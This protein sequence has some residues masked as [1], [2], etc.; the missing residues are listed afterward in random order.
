MKEHRI[1]SGLH[2]EMGQRAWELL[3]E[4]FRRFWAAEAANIPEYCEFPDL[5]LGAQWE[6]PEKEAFYARYC[7]ME[8][9]KA[10]PH[11]P[12]DREWRGTTFG[13]VPDP[14][15]IY[16]ALGCYLKRT[17]DCIAAGDVTDSA[18]FAG[19]GAHV[20]QDCSNPG[21]VFNNIMLNRLFPVRGQKLIF[22]HRLMDS[23]PIDL[24]AVRSRP[25]LLGRNADEAV[26]YLAE[27]II[28]N[29]GLISA[30]MVKLCQA[31]IANRS[32]TITSI[33]QKWNA[34]AIRHTLNFWHTAFVLAAGELPSGSDR[35][36]AETSLA[37]KP[38]ITAYDERFDRQQ[39]I[40]A[41][42]P[43]YNNR[44]PESDP[45]RSTM[46][47]NPYP[48]EPLINCA[49]SSEGNLLPLQ[50]DDGG[51]I[52]T[53]KGV[54]SGT[55]GVATW[56]VPGNVFR[57]FEAAA[58]LHPETSPDVS[59]TFGV[60][61]CESTPRLLAKATTDRKKGAIRFKVAIPPE[62]RTL[63]LLN[64]GGDGR[65]T[66]VWLDPVLKS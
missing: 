19:T 63:S 12:Q 2:K 27:K 7:I 37:D 42:I 61:C 10:A 15:K 50:L 52:L 66:A 35:R 20:I 5:H 21:H 8:N 59:C 46:S 16:N 28:G 55:Y 49:C 23:W 54:A 11:G 18:R 51:T 13:D 48:F 65:S 9:G 40:A 3:P 30:D 64:A 53:G 39:Y 36:F 6:D 22:M 44:Y 56:S 29:M 41:G 32:R 45:P 31:I 14:E 47:T 57:T 62:C 58:G 1:M 25:V 33:M 24:D 17:I 60:W 43:F 26:Y 4:K 34:A 38:L